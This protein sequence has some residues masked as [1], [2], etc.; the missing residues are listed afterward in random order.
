MEEDVQQAPL[1]SSFLYRGSIQ[2]ELKRLEDAIDQADDILHYETAHNPELLYATDIVENFLRRKRRVCYGGTA[3]NAILPEKMKFYDKDK[4]LPDYDFFSPNPQD[5]LL[6]LAKDLQ[7]AGFTEVTERI[8][9]HEGTHKLL[10]NFIAIADIT[11]MNPDL[12][13]IVHQRALKKDGIWF[14]NFRLTS[15]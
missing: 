6:L 2:K 4:D 12:Y 15:P 13:K 1:K 8:G 9:I 7:H 3:I 5:D 14:A 11:Y 10:V